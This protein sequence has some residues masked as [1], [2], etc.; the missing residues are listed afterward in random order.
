MARSWYVESYAED[1]TS[2]ESSETYGSFDEAYGAVKD[3][4]SAGKIA[5]VRAPLDATPEQLNSF[6]QLGLLEKL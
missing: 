1:G 3:I 5:R 6:N 2:A 4:R